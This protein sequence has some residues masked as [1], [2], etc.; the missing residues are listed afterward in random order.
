MPEQYRVSCRMDCFHLCRFTVSVEKNK[1]TGLK[2]DPNHPLTRGVVCPK[3]RQLITRHHHP[4]RLTQPLIRT[5]TGFSPISYDEV[6]PLL[7]DKLDR[8]IRE[9]GPT[10]VLNYTSAGYGGAKNSIQNIF[11]NTLG[12]DSRFTGSLCWGA[13]IAAQKYDFGQ[14]RSN[15]PLDVLNADMVILWGRNPKTTNLHLYTLLT[16]AEK[17]GTRIIVIDPNESATAR[18]FGNHIRVN[19]GTDGALALAMCR[20]IIGEGLTDRM[21]VSN[22]VLGF[23]RFAESIRAYS[24]EWAQKI[25]GVPAETIRELTLDYAHTRKA[26]IYPGYG[27]QRYSNGGNAVRSTNALAAITGHIGYSGA[28]VH[29]ASKS[30]SPYVSGPEAGSEGKVQERRTFPAHGLGTFMAEANQPPVKAAFFFCANPMV[31]TPDLTRAM[32]G[33]EQVEFK[34]V[35]DQFMTDT[36]SR[37]DLIIPGT[38]VFEQDD[39]FLT[40]MFSHWINVS[41]KAV[42]PPDTLIPEFEFYLRLA[43]HMGMD[44]GFSSSREFLEQCTGPLIAALKRSGDFDGVTLEDLGASYPRFSKHDVAWNDKEFATPSGQIEIY[45]DQ[46]AKDGLSPIPEYFPPLSSSADFPLR[47]LTCHSASAM[48][49]Q[50]FMEVTDLPDI[51]VAEATAEKYGLSKGMTVEVHGENGR[52]KA[53]VNTDDSIMRNTAFM[54]QG[55][56]HKSGAVNFLTRERVTDMGGQAAYYE[57]F[58][59]LVPE[60]N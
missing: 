5:A 24:P 7:A 15:S 33:I 43:E 60:I 37:A 40:S 50:G 31:Q 1:I 6:I 54:V 4:D 47:L 38:T 39:I 29:Y 11:F 22:H 19:P 36:A 53:I 51:F 20:E 18:R 48:H 13:G 27:M 44:L 45:C 57:A 23:N 9:H 16:E 56:W 49:S 52:I 42:A 8:I 35:F 21:F 55:Y 59:K 26:V 3:A 28:G 46:A 17:K 34:V 30:M 41:E 10:T 2:G 14:A 25:T 58:C 12:G 32:A